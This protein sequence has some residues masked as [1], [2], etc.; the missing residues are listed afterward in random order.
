MIL[1]VRQQIGAASGRL[2][3]VRMEPVRHQTVRSL[4]F[5]G[6]GDAA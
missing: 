5:I 4:P 3:N 6:L 1:D 2:R